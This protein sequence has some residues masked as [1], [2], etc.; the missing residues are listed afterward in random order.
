MVEPQ[1][2]PVERRRSDVF[3]D[4]VLL[5]LGVSVAEL[6]TRRHRNRRR[7]AVSTLAAM[8]IAL[9]IAFAMVAGSTTSHALVSLW[10]TLF[11]GI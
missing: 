6:P 10:H 11:P 2:A 3:N 7:I 8:A 1:A 9:V 5:G 4:P